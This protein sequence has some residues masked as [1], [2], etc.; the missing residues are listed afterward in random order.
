[1]F[2]SPN[3]T[4][5]HNAIAISG[6]IVSSFHTVFSIPKTSGWM[7]NFE[8]IWLAFLLPIS[9][10]KNSNEVMYPTE[11][12]LNFPLYVYTFLG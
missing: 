12:S 3:I 6:K 10:Q 9:K 2:L 1:M 5:S 7:S 8:K 4:I 11:N